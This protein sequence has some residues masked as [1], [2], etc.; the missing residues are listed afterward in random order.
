MSTARYR[1]LCKY[2]GDWLATPLYRSI[3]LDELGDLRVCSG[4]YVICE[5]LERVQYVGSV[6]RPTS[7]TGVADRLRE[8]LREGHK[9]MLWKTAWV[10]PLT[11]DAPASVVRSLEACIGAE[12]LP[13]GGDRLPRLL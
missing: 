7:P 9:R 3:P 10:I 1:G 8:H 11:P 5:P 2:A 13:L 6:C 12:L 4:A